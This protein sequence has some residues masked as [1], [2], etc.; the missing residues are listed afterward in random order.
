MPGQMGQ[1]KYHH[2]DPDPVWT[3]TLRESWGPGTT[4][5]C[6][7]QW[8]PSSRH[9]REPPWGLG[10][11]VA[12]HWCEK[13]R[14]QWVKVNVGMEACTPVPRR[15]SSQTPL[16]GRLLTAIPKHPPLSHPQP[17]RLPH[18][19]PLLCSRMPEAPDPHGLRPSLHQ[20]SWPWTR[21]CH[22]CPSLGCWSRGL[23]A[24]HHSPL[25]SLP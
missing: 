20:V 18:P 3:Y 7:D 1:E 5:A 10:T 15:A 13:P 4:E 12:G 24:H 25:L 11:R 16:S 6:R 19:L 17:P 21:P 23:G 9:G 14:V 2:P 8:K 22:T